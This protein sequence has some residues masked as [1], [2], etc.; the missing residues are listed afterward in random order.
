MAISGNE[1]FEAAEQYLGM[2]GEVHR[3]NSMSRAYFGLYHFAK[4]KLEGLCASTIQ[5]FEHQELISYLL[6]EDNHEGA[7]VAA[8]S[9]MKV[10]YYLNQ[11]KM[12]RVEAD[13]RLGMNISEAHANFILQNAQQGIQ[14][15]TQLASSEELEKEEQA[16]GEDDNKPR[17]RA[18]KVIR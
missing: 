5:R 2:E 17:R 16:A 7:T 13:Y 4:L 18:I 15:C 6:K 1:F 8:K 12:A 3:R 9:L 11:A 14:F 10:G